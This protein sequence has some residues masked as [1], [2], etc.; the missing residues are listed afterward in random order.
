MK[1]DIKMVRC[2]FR[3]QSKEVFE[4]NDQCERPTLVKMFPVHSEPFGKYT[5]SGKLEMYI[6]ND[7]A[8]NELVIGKEYYIDI[9]RA[10]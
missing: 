3:V 2:K 6:Q 8:E 7:E 5:P 1:G 9:T 10:E 4:K